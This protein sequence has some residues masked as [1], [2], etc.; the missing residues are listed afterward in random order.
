MSDDANKLAGATA[1]QA[2]MDAGQAL[3]RNFFEALTNQHVAMQDSGGMAVTNM[4]MPDPA[5][6]A[7]FQQEFA[8]KHTALWTS[9]LA[10]SQGEAVEPVVPVDPRDK[11]FSSP[12]W[13]T[14]PM[15][16]YLRQ[17][18][19]INAAFLT[20]VAAAVPLNDGRAKQRLNFLTRQYIDALAP[21]N[22]A[23]TNPEFIAAALQ[24]KGESITR[25]IQNMLADLQKGRVSTT[26][27]TVFEVGRNLGVSP[28]AVIFENELMQ[29]IQYSPLTD[30]VAQVPFLIVPPCINK[31][32]IL[33]L[34]PE[35]SFVRYVVEQGHTVFLVSWKN[36]GPEDANRTWD[37]YVE[38]G[39]L[40]AIEI[41]RKVTKVK[42]PNILGFCV[43]G[44]I[45]ATALAVARAR[46]DDPVASVTF[47]TTMLD[48]S[49]TGEIGCLVDEAS[50][51][52]RENTIGKGGL[53][54]GQELANVFSFLQ[55]NNLVWQYVIGNYLKGGT[56]APFDLLYWNSD[57]TNLPGP[58]LAWYLRNM[59]LEN[60]LRLPGRLTVLG[61]K[62]DL[63][64]IDVPVYF[65]A[66]REDHIVPWK[67]S[68]LGRA[69]VGG[70]TVFTLGASGHIAGTINPAA[71]N[72]RSYWT[73][74]NA[75]TSPDEWLAQAEE[76][77]GSWWPHW[78]EWLKQFDGKQVPARAR[79]GSK[80]FEAIEPAPG[81]YVKARA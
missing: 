59:Y 10:G 13:T 15:F 9:M 81:R 57:S 4:P 47:L 30:T 29:L 42:K 56:P 54:K 50:V 22:F 31:F 2:M 64:K 6:L 73:S 71:K 63:G 44:T 61:Q 76:H 38:K 7:K 33:D 66:A 20:K 53:L 65:F 45:L 36:A 12:E 78:I 17:A 72:K 32:Y 69:L 8:S 5:E 67:T 80:D 43:G 70:D 51:Q 48:F 11:R 46:G 39:P 37:E 1:M 75:P 52:A 58:F 40:T 16:D 27:E 79:L 60:N 77:P 55:A 41:V 14:N 49:D 23:A 3:A 35:N 26:D 18:Y 21:S 68:Y 74:A 62:V 28:G 25:G 24:T 19:L 34:Q